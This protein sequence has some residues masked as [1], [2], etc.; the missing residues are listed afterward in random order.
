M[1]SRCLSYI[2]CLISV[3]LTLL[4]AAGYAADAMTLEQTISTVLS[5]N[6]KARIA[7]EEAEGAEAVRRAQKTQFFPTLSTSYQATR[8]DEEQRSAF[9]GVTVPQDQYLFALTATQPLFTGFSLINRYDIAALGVDISALNAKQVRQQL[10]LEAKTAFFSVLKAEKLAAVGKEAVQLLEA[11]E[12]DARQFYDVGMTPLNDLLKAQ[13]ELANTRQELVRARN[14]LDVARANFNTLLR[15]P[16][17]APVDIREA[18]TYQPLTLTV[19]ECL[20]IAQKE[21]PEIALADAQIE[22]SEKEVAL[23]KKD[24][25]PTVSLSGNYYKQGTDWDVDGGDGISDP[26]GW[27]VQATAT[28]NFWEWG[29]T[30]HNV[31]EKKHQL[32]QARY[33]LEQVRDT[34][35]FQTKEAYLRAREAE[36]NIQTVETAI[37]QARENHRISQEQYKQQVGTSTDVLDARTL[38]SKTMTNYYNALYD[39]EIAKA[40][41]ARAM[42]REQVE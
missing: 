8:R 36:R 35:R 37:T 9:L 13:V 33:T 14:A 31:S 32:N 4:P 11:L 34:V 22:V 6:L 27:E 23:V 25:Y 41:L 18:V 2:V 24:Y 30:A 28:W 21:R 42:G 17:D 20:A 39:Y 19:D 10:V 3:L 29:R 7:A 12:N 1:K 16:I 15:R 40:A 38:L 5:A 26:D